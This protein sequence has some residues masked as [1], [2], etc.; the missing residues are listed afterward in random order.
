MNL[1]R[2]KLV[3]ETGCANCP[4]NFSFSQGPR[5]CLSSEVSESGSERKSERKSEIE[6]END[7]DC[8][9]T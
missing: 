8:L 3:V 1:E 6:N 9:R 5:V 2:E 4:T 7:D